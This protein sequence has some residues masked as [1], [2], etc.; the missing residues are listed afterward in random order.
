MPPIP[1]LHDGKETGNI[2]ETPDVVLGLFRPI[3]VFSEGE[4]IPKTNPGLVCTK[5]LFHLTVLKQRGGESGRA[6]W[7]LFDMATSALSDTELQ[8]VNFNEE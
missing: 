7:L 8:R 6:F 4:I 1:A 2:E 3:S 5:N